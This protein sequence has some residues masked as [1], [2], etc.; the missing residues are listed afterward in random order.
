MKN[1][2]L[3]LI[4]LCLAT[5]CAS[6]T[7]IS[8]ASLHNVTLGDITA[9]PGCGSNCTTHSFTIPDAHPR[10][11]W[12]A[13]R[14]AQAQSWRTANPGANMSAAWLHVVTGS[15][16]ATDINT[17]LTTTVSAEQYSPS[18]NGSDTARWSGEAMA[19]IYDWC[20]DELTTQQKSDF[21]YNINST[22]H[23]WYDYLTGINQQGWGGPSMPDSNYFWGNLRNDIDFGIA[24]Y[25]DDQTF[26]ETLLD[27]GLDTRYTDSFLPAALIPKLI[28]G[29]P[30]EGNAY[31]TSLPSYPIVP[32]QTMSQNGRDIFNETD[33]FKQF[34]Y[35][36]IYAT[37]PAVT[38][39]PNQTASYFTIQP[40]GDDEQYT[41]GGM[42][43][44]RTAYQ[45]LMNFYSN[46][47][48][49]INVGKDARQW[50]NTVTAD[51][52]TLATSNTFLAQDLTPSARATSNL[53][54]DYYAS[55]MQYFYGRKAWDI[56]SAYFFWQLGT[57]TEHRHTDEGNFHIWRGGRWLT[58]ETTGYCNA[59]AG[60]GYRVLGNGIDQTGCGDG[61]GLLA[62]NI[63][64]FGTPLYTD[65]IQLMPSRFDEPTVLR[66]ESATGYSY[67]NV[68]L[69]GRYKWSGYPQY[70]RG[71]VVHVE[72]ELLF[73]RELETTIILDRITTGDV[74]RGVD[75]GLSAANQVNTFLLHSEVDPTLEDATHITITN[76]TQVLRMTTLVPANPTRRVINEQS[77]SGCTLGIGQYRIELDTS[78]AAQRYFL[79]VLQARAGDGQNI[80][81]SVVDSAPGNLLSGTFTVTLHP[82]TGP[83]TTIVF[84]KGQTSSGGSVNISGAGVV[85]LRSDVQTISYTDN[86]PVWG[87]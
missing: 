16:C 73:L 37:T 54:L 26:A 27:D 77:C 83:D 40:Y 17:M 34:V 76:G 58:R 80:T 62:H 19:L 81:A 52:G 29:V 72:R 47:Y 46:Y 5:S 18:G 14:L 78:G 57:G 23:G 56:S 45:D 44:I 50:W 75:T 7:T 70:E 39:H 36:V 43:H 24:L 48:S 41:D 9:T 60:Y 38:Y 85:N 68:D 33:F 25:T 51:G 87:Q 22:G 11:W 20:Y 32:F 65:D 6:A 63:V 84:N 61:K 53:P 79:N 30:G 2:L 21:L 49:A 3:A 59:I 13:A 15:S 28:G 12:N 4:I 10:L 86:G 64:V 35:Y 8:G 1:W 71:A 74:I 67:A 66:I 82:A 31:G 55:G 42:L 69:T